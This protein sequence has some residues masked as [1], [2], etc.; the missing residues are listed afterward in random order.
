MKKLFSLILAIMFT[1]IA[2]AGCGVEEDPS[3]NTITSSETAETSSKITTTSKPTSTSSK[4][5]SSSSKKKKTYSKAETSSKEKNT[6]TE[7]EKIFYGKDPDLYKL[8]LNSKGN[9]ARIAALMKKAQKGG[10]YKIAVIGGS[11]SQGAGASDVAFSYG[12]LVNEWWCANF[13]NATFEFVNAGIGSTNPEM[14]CYRMEE[15]LLKFNPDFVVVD[16]SVNSNN[17]DD[18]YNT[19]CSVIYRI[20][21]QKNSPA[22]MAIDFTNCRQGANYGKKPTEA[23]KPDW[24]NAL[25]TYDLPSV[26]YHKYIWEKIDKKIIEWEDIG[27]DYIHPNDNGHMVA[28]N[29]ITCYLENILNNLSKES[30]KVT[31]PP[32]PE[33]NRYL[34]LG[35]IVNTAKNVTMTGGFYSRDNTSATKRGWIYNKTKEDSSLTIPVP[36]NKKLKIFIRFTDDEEGSI[37]VTDANQKTRTIF[38]REAKN[39][40]LIDMGACT[41]SIT[42][43]PSKQTGEFIIYGIGVNK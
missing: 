26:S 35:Y 17:D 2:F 28:A 29:I 16:F 12:N 32:K 25:K 33:V 1:L 38:S 23:G 10:K 14:A 30:T 4:M 3:S 31:A 6:Y 21:S 27:A 20:L 37:T 24:S 22:V 15:D 9:S 5:Q 36:E 19:V 34:N 7:K 39:P 42:F 13:P 11:I 43:T 8:S 40:A 18:A 41:G